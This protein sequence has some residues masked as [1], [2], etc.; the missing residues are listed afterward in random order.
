MSFPVMFMGDS[1]LNKR[2][3][4]FSGMY[5]SFNVVIQTSDEFLMIVLE[6]DKEDLEIF[7]WL[8]T[9]DQNSA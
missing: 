6:I 5:C 9:T 3:L 8:Y 7:R 1:P 2:I 4:K